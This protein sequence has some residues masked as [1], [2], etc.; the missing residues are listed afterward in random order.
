MISYIREVRSLHDC[1]FLQLSIDVDA[2]LTLTPWLLRDMVDNANVVLNEEEEHKITARL[3]FF[4]TTR[5]NS[6]NYYVVCYSHPFLSCE[7]KLS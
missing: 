7:W 1:H 3:H 4:I 2:H 6:H 5:H